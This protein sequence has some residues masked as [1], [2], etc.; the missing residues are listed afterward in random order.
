MDP[1][2]HKFI[3]EQG[4]S[5]I[6]NS[7]IK[8][9]VVSKINTTTE[10]AKIEFGKA[11]DS[12]VSAAKI[13][14]GN[15]ADMVKEGAIAVADY[16]N[17]VVEK[18]ADTISS[19]VDSIGSFFSRLYD[20]AKSLF[21]SDDLKSQ[22]VTSRIGE[23]PIVEQTSSKNPESARIN[24]VE[25][26]SDMMSSLRTGD[27]M[28]LAGLGDFATIGDIK[29]LGVTDSEIASMRTLISTHF[30]ETKNLFA[31]DALKIY[32]AICVPIAQVL[33]KI[34]HIDIAAL[35]NALLTISFHETSNSFKIASRVNSAMPQGLF[36]Y[37]PSVLTNLSN[38]LNMK[39]VP[40]DITS[41]I[42]FGVNYFGELLRRTRASFDLSGR[43]PVPIVYK[44][45][46]ADGDLY[47]VL[48]V[49]PFS[50]SRQY[51]RL[52]LTMIMHRA[53]L[54][55]KYITDHMGELVSKRLPMM[56]YGCITE[57]SNFEA[58]EIVQA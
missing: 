28:P 32:T 22:D 20:K 14:A 40:G 30:P 39:F 46:K 9:K 11:Y 34:E 35:A 53:G 47:K 15:A 52:V 27:V 51:N 43:I 8:S 55:V 49:I 50:F 54:S 19:T 24:R 23:S 13:T 36:Q 12:A 6:N 45:E 21:K 10:A 33:G 17:K 2:L 57:V 48:S 38:R 7:S 4:Q 3:A 25:L 26:L 44:D 37:V 31:N 42:A 58:P 16:G 5:N 41:E 18:A 56:L 1:L 29:A